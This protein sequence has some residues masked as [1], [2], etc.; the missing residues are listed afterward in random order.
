MKEV[1]LTAEQIHELAPYELNFKQATEAAWCSYPGQ[2]GIAKMCDIWQSITGSPYPYSPGCPNC[3]LNLVRDLGTLYFAQ[4]DAVLAAEPKTE[5]VEGSEGSEVAEAPV[6]EPKAAEQ[7]KR[8]EPKK[9]PSKAKK[10]A[11]K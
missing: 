10:P 8:A 6:E 9:A 4:K 5:I 7:E 11:K 3:L 1:K 2:A